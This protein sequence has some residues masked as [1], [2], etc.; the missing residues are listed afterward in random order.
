MIIGCRPAAKDA[1][2]AEGNREDIYDFF[3]SRVRCVEPLIEHLYA[4]D[5]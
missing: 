3:I 2:I 4:N 1:G 5:R